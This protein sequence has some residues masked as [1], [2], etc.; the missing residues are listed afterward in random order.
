M[1]KLFNAAFAATILCG[2]T[3]AALI[4]VRTQGA[5]SDTDLR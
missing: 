4:K 2:I 3:E 1:I 5:A